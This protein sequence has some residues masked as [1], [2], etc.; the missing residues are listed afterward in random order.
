MARLPNLIKL[1][2]LDA[3]IFTKKLGH[4][5][6]LPEAPEESYIK[7]ENR[8]IKCV[9]PLKLSITHNNAISIKINGFDIIKNDLGWYMYDEDR[10]NSL[11]QKFAFMR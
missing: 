8:C 5:F 10:M 9:M 7:Y 4:E 2:I 1:P 11:C 3:I 6:S